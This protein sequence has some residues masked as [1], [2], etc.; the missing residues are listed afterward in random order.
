MEHIKPQSGG[1]F[2]T[3]PEHGHE[4]TDINIKSILGFG[5]F[6]LFSAVVIHVMLWGFYK[7]LE[8]DF[9]KSQSKPLPVVQQMQDKA[10]AQSGAPPAA[11]A[12]EA[13]V[14][15]QKQI[16]ERLKATFPTPRLQPD[17][18]RDMK[19]PAFEEVKENIRQ[20]AQQEQVSALVKS[21]R[22]K[23]S[24]SGQ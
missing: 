21:L 13:G 14:E 7:A 15:S 24:I 9:D 22:E 12:G 18:V 1:K 16:V 8:K 10:Q 17:D 20:R 5:V 11:E 3:D 23:S 4:E 2:T 19:V 6:L